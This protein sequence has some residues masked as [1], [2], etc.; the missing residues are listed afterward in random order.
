MICGAKGGRLLLEGSR[1]TYFCPDLFRFAEWLFLGI[2]KPMGLIP[3]GMVSCALY[4]ENE[5]LNV[6]RSPHLYIEHLTKRNLINEQTKEWFITNNIYMS[7]HSLDSLVCMYDYDGDQGTVNNHPT[8]VQASYDH[9]KRA[10]GKKIVPL[11]Y[12]LGIAKKEEINKE[13]MYNALIDSYDKDIGEISNTISKILNEN[14]NNPDLSTVAKLCYY[15]NAIID[16]P[17]TRWL[18][19]LPTYLKDKIKEY[20]RKKLPAFFEY[21]KNKKKKNL[22]N[23]N[24]SVVNMLDDIIV[25]KNIFFEDVESFDYKKL[26]RNPRRKIDQGIVDLYEKLNES[27]YYNMQKKLKLLDDNE[28]DKKVKIKVTHN[29]YYDM[30]QKFHELNPDVD[31]VVDVLVKY[32]YQ[33]DNPFKDSLWGLYG[34]ILVQ[35]LKRNILN[36]I[37]CKDC[38]KEVKNPS[39]RQI[40]CEECQI[41]HKRKLDAENKRRKR[42]IMSV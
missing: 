28:L 41:I 30:R 18:P 33:R 40:R 12:H 26:M 4:R 1:R 32:L 10:Y 15:N 22:S 11:Y 35:N 17:K 7:T 25:T 19:E 16:F 21:A 20:K 6:N 2:K 24:E 34:K 14:H 23:K 8:Y 31:Y 38:R 27:K 29:V 39:Q 37:D 9:L 3:K 36:V 13:N 5:R 42:K